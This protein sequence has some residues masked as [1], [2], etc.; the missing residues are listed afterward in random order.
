[1]AEVYLP[2]ALVVLF[3][4]APRR[5]TL[6]ADSVGALLRLL[7]SRWPGMWDRLCTAGPAIREH[8]NIFVD[9]E[10]GTLQT[11]LRTATIVRIIPALSGG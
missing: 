4:G 9:G 8:M 5:L 2:P 3:P 11:P 6:E 1:M 10:K 7:D